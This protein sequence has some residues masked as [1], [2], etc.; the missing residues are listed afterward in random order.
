[1]TERPSGTTSRNCPPD[2]TRERR[3]RPTE[4]TV[5]YNKN[6]THNEQNVST[7]GATAGGVDDAVGT[8]S[9]CVVSPWFLAIVGFIG[10]NL[11]QSSFTDACPAEKLLPGCESSDDTATV[12]PA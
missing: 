8:R 12:D 3:D 11:I 1:M 2:T 10:L 6:N 7:P 5:L 4:F 9:R